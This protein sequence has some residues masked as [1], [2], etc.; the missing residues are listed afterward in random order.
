MSIWNKAEEV[1]N[2]IVPSALMKNTGISRIEKIAKAITA[3]V[4]QEREACAKVA[5]GRMGVPARK[6]IAAAIRNRSNPSHALP[7]NAEGGD[8]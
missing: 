5:E 6:N 1:A 7:L 4:E 3:A 8:K 2:A